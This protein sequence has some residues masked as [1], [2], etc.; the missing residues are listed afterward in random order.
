MYPQA[1][2]FDPNAV[3]DNGLCD[4]SCHCGP[5]TLWDPE[6]QSCEV[7]CGADHDLDGVVGTGDLLLFLTA[8]ATPCDALGM[9]SQ[10]D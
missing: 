4:F 7:V 2:N 10:D 9:P 6:T 8:F 3:V 1:C 5:G